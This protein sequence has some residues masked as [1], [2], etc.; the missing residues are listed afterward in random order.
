MQWN[1]YATKEKTWIEKFIE[2]PH[3]LFFTSALVFA[4]FFMILSFASLLGANINFNKFHIYGL[5]YGVFINAILGFLLTVIPRY[6]KSVLV[7]KEE[8]ISIFILYNIG[9]FLL[10][11][12]VLE[13]S[14]V[15]LGSS[16]LF[17]SIVFIE[18]ILKG[19]D[20]KQTESWYLAILIGIGAMLTIL[21]SFIEFSFNIIIF[22]W[23]LFPLVFTVASRM[24]PAFYAVYFNTSI[25]QKSPYF[26]PLTLF[27]FFLIGVFEM[28][29]LNILTSLVALIMG[30]NILYF[31]ISNRLYIKA[32]AIL[33]ILFIAISWLCIGFFALALEKM[34]L[35]YSLNL[36]LHIFTI[37]FLSTILIGF[38]Y[39]VVLGHSGNQIIADKIA[40]TIFTMIQLALISRVFASILFI[41]ESKAWIGL[42]HLGIM[43]WIMLFTIWLVK[44]AKLLI[45]F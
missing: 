7:K 44:H 30:I 9:V 34:F 4:I 17:S 13:F 39:R 41:V 31:I 32:P 12:N 11:T 36:S 27:G 6:T 20:Y 2:Q 16:L 24:L 35:D 25:K 19:I 21:N 14:K 23:F 22:W 42:V 8:Y 33:S 29:E 3:Q 38:G 1:P 40:K 28:F 5:V 18:T 15:F 37:G 45:R 43:F 26:L 10:F